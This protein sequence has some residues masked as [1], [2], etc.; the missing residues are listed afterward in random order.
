MKIAKS[1]I[2]GRSLQRHCCNNTLLS[3]PV[4]TPTLPPSPDS[5]GARESLVCQWP[6]EASRWEALT[7]KVLVLPMAGDRREKCSRFGNTGA[8]KYV[9]V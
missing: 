1:K 7:G 6:S 9:G 3:E 5:L 2:S 8:G 4:L